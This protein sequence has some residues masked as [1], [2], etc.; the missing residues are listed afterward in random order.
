M[1]RCGKKMK[2]TGKKTT[3][4]NMRKKVFHD[5]SYLGNLQHMETLKDPEIKLLQKCR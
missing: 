2:E 3:K 1:R 5:I 4:K